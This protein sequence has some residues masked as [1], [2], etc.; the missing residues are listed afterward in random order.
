MVVSVVA[1]PDPPLTRLPTVTFIRLT[2][3]VMGALTSVHSRL[4][5]EVS[6]A[7]SA[8]FNDAAASPYDALVES[9]SDGAMTWALINSTE[10]PKSALALTA[11]ALAWATT[12]FLL[13]RSAWNGRG[14]ILNSKSP[15]WTIAPSWKGASSISPLTRALTVAVVGDERYPLY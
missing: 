3:P 9:K 1:W 15:A 6:R 13:S 14:S 2:R 10:R 5:R 12:A 4:R 8:A 11:V 7:A